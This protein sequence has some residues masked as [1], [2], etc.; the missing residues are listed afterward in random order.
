MDLA[1]LKRKG[2]L[3]NGNQRVGKD[4]SASQHERLVFKS[5]S[6]ELR[7]RQRTGT[8]VAKTTQDRLR[9]L[10][11]DLCSL[12]KKPEDPCSPGDGAMPAP[13]APSGSRR[14]NC[15][16]VTWDT[17]YG[18]GSACAGSWTL[19]ITLSSA[20]SRPPATQPASASLSCAWRPEPSFKSINR[21]LL[22]SCLN[23]PTAYNILRT[24]PIV[25]PKS[26]D[27]P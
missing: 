10:G 3:Q 2:N 12:L 11:S 9:S 27:P 16:R 19:V 20:L 17:V 8:G 4:A 22:P 26:P 13:P 25:P 5:T 1:P 21:I 14:I 23:P 15:L 7:D 24:N 6:G 18:A